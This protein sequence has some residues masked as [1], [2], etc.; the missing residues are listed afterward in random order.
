MTMLDNK[1]IIRRV[2]KTAEN[3]DIPGW[4][5]PFAADGVFTDESIQ[6]ESRARREPS[7]KCGL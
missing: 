6:V 2:Y 5:V 7:R 3:K 4:I 1:E